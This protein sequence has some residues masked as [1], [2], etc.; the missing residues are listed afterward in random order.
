[1]ENEKVI[2]EDIEVIKQDVENVKE[3]LENKSEDKPKQ[4]LRD[5]IYKNI[6]IPLKTMDRFITGLVVALGIALL[7]GVVI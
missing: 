5:S 1:M 6:D 4:N 7:F 2:K 3:D